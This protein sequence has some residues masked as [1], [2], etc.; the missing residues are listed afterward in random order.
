M[1]INQNQ[2]NM[3][4]EKQ[5]AI[6]IG[7]T[8]HSLRAWRLNGRGPRYCKIGRAVRYRIED[9]QRFIESRLING[10]EK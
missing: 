3:L 8:V 1:L 10:A 7:L 2:Q 9:V 6:I 4:N 5:V